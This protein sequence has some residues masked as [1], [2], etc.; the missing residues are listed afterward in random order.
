MK[1][2]QPT[3]SPVL[4]ERI[5]RDGPD[6]LTGRLSTRPWPRKWEA[7]IRDE[8]DC[9]SF[10]WR[11]VK[12]SDCA[13]LVTFHDLGERLTRLELQ[14]DIVPV[15]PLE[16]AQFAL[17][18]ADARARNELRR[19]FYHSIIIHIVTFFQHTEIALPVVAETVIVTNNYAVRMKP[20]Q[21]DS[22]ERVLNDVAGPVSRGPPLTQNADRSEAAIRSQPHLRLGE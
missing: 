4:P 15:R 3:E 7:E 22:R 11:S 9:E 5:E 17:R 13:G 10:A 19:Y 1:D 12:G 14:L 18:L 8:R 21:T 16:A 6:A 2:P 20:G